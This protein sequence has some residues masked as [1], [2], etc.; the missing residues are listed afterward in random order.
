MGMGSDWLLER[1][2][3][4]S[5]GEEVGACCADVAEAS[6]GE[7]RDETGEEVARRME[8]GPVVRDERGKFE[9]GDG[10]HRQLWM[11]S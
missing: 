7:W 1:E 3:E 11:V 2:R 10:V 5:G 9:D 6:G 4:E 8:G